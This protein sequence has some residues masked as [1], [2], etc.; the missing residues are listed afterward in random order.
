LTH[1]IVRNLESYR[2]DIEQQPFTP[3]DESTLDELGI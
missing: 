3:E 2:K 1:L